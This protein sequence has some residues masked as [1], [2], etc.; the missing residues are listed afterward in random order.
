[1]LK[2][3]HIP[4][5]SFGENIAYI[6]RDCSFYKVDDVNK[7]TKLEIHKGGRTI[8]AF[9]QIIAEEGVLALDEIGLNDDAFKSLD[10][11]EGTEV[12]V[13][14]AA[15]SLSTS[16]LRK[17][18]S[19]EI[20]TSGEYAAI[21]NDI[22]AGRY[23]KMDIAAFL[24]ACS[25]S[26]SSTELVSFTEALVAKKILH[27][28]EKNMVVDHHCL[29]GVP[30]N[31]TDLIVLAITAAYGLPIAKSCI[32]SLTSCSGVADTM[33]V[34]AEVNLNAAK[35]QKLVRANNGAI[36]N[37]EAMEETKVNHLL[38]DVRSQ[39]GINQNELVMASILAMMIS[40]GVS[41]LVLDIPVGPHARIHS[42]NEAIRIRK[43]V[44]YIGDMLGLSIDVVTT[45]G[46]E[47]IGNGIGA[48]LEARDVM[49]ILRNKED[50]PAD[51][52]EKSLF[53]AG[54]VLEFDAQLRGGQGY[55]VA[56]EILESGRAFEAFQKIVN[57]QG[58][59]EVPSVGAY[60]RE[61]VAPYDGVV[62]TINN[63]IISKIGIYAG[64]TQCLGS[65]VDLQKKSGDRVHAGE[66]LYT[67]YSCN[68]AD[69]DVVSQLVE[70][71]SGYQIEAD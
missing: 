36:V 50:A 14:L 47:P 26:M 61:V 29:G 45:D 24:V 7:V 10:M 34:M 21:I 38:H 9:L 20:L 4:V 17:K 71:D 63:D 22:A 70:H 5:K 35:F 13:G 60:V 56:K 27:W 55:A 64:A 40:T 67:I 69:F 42:T 15:P 11:S 48:V 19:G 30:G 41:H 8:Y 66:V 32:H 12:H 23:S 31:K 68:S 16:A 46:S 18:I 54:R 43:Q 37:Y 3:K 1:M 62:K 51:L 58:A 39:L 6:H 53:L 52:R 2:L 57:A 28:D 33:G 49:K 44:E 65:G 25:S 59:K